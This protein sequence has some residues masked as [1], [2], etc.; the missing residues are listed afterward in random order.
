MISAIGRSCGRSCSI[1][2]KMA[3]GTMRITAFR[4][5]KISPLPSYDFKSVSK[6]FSGNRIIKSSRFISAKPY[7]A[8]D[9]VE[10]DTNASKDLRNKKQNIEEKRTDLKRLKELLFQ[11]KTETK[12]PSKQSKA[13]TKSSKHGPTASAAKLADLLSTL[14]F[15]PS[16]G[17]PAEHQLKSTTHIEGFEGTQLHQTV[18][19]D[20]LRNALSTLKQDSSSAEEVIMAGSRI[21]SDRR[22][23]IEGTYE[24]KKRQFQDKDKRKKMTRTSLKTGPRFHMFDSVQKKWSHEHGGDDKTIFQEMA[25]LEIQDLGL[26]ATIQSGF[27]DLM[28]KVDQQWSFPIDNEICKTDEDAVGFDEHVFLEHLLE[29]FPKTGNIQQFMEL[30]VTGLQQNPHLSVADKKVHIQWFKEYFANM[31]DE[32]VQL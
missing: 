29:D 9:W 8:K 22:S 30:V 15:K 10:S 5:V 6:I 21:S 3:A 26:S 20:R 12:P 7:L 17:Q 25:E 14:N 4:V 27:H 1:F 18:K 23:A 2:F 19:V 13:K 16:E 11:G 32:Q 31:P 28:E 24:I